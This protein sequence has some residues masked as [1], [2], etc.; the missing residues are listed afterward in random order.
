[1]RAVD[2]Y[3][4]VAILSFP[5]NHLTGAHPLRRDEPLADG[6]QVQF[7]N[8]NWKVVDLRMDADPP[9]AYFERV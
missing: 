4:Y 8:R 5:D 9:V 2:E 6:D 1:M 3:V 7:G